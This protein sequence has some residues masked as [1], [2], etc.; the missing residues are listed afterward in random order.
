[1]IRIEGLGKRFDDGRWAVRGVDLEVPEGGWL[2]LIGASGSGKTTTLRCINRLVVPTEGRVALAGRDVC[3]APP[4]ELRRGIGYVMQAVGLFPHW[5]VGENVGVVPRLLGWSP[6]AIAARVDELLT[7]VGL[8]PEVYRDRPPDALSGGQRQRVGVARAL[9]A[10]AKVLLMDEPFGALD[11]VTRDLLQ[12]EVR[13][14]HD[15]LGLTT[16]MVTHDMAGALRLADRIAVMDQGRLVRVGTP[17]ELLADPG[18][19]TVA[20]LLDA[21]RRNAALLAE[22]VS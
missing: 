19:D 2:A 17:R 4:E 3:D 7:M 1:M 18:H 13:A 16:V 12:T 9:A 15:A 22:L 8:P 10:R 11:P 6:A 20:A 5:T 21:P 14:L